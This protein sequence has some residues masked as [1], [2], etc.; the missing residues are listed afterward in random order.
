VYL[1]AS[2]KARQNLCPVRA[3]R[4]QHSIEKKLRNMNIYTYSYLSVCEGNS[5]S[6]NFVGIPNLWYAMREIGR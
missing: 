5:G 4:R 3:E 1:P 6:E 2:L